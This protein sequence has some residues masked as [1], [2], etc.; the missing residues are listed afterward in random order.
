[1]IRY[2]GAVNTVISATAGVYGLSVS[3]GTTLNGCIIT[4]R[5]AGT[6]SRIHNSQVN[7][8]LNGTTASNGFARHH[9]IVSG[10]WS[11]VSRTAAW[12]YPEHWLGPV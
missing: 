1:M 4:N 9:R 11:A 6:V 3:P 10:F 5:S 12:C 7:V 2:N 8:A